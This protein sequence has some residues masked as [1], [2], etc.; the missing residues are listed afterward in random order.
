MIGRRC[1][2]RRRC[3]R[4]LPPRSHPLAR[5]AAAWERLRARRER[6]AWMLTGMDAI[7]TS[8]DARGTILSVW[9]HPDDETY[10]AGGLMAAAR[11]RGQRVVCASASA[12]EHGTDDPATWPPDRLG[13]GAPVG[14]GG[15][16]GRAR[17]HRAPHRAGC[18]T[19]PSPT[20]TT[21]G[22]DWVGSSARR[23][24]SRHDRH[25]RSRR[26]DVPPRPRRRAPLGHRRRGATAAAPVACCTPRRPS[27]TWTASAPATRSGASTWATSAR[28]ACRPSEL[29]LHV[30]LDRLG[31]RPQGRRAAQ[32]WRR[33]RVA[34][35]PTSAWR[36]TPT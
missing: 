32:R 10:L 7:A 22:V 2:W 34:P 18:P 30:R 15:G 28:P 25:L 24:P 35:S 36:C 16:D 33:R 23:R 1:S 8:P 5:T 14:G 11:D 4:P 31:A 19:A 3:A 17:G 27:S 21:A 12:G 13:A 29:A 6:T 9:A 26:H 20:T